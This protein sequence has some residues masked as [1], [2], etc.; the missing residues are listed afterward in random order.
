MHLRPTILNLTLMLPFK[1]GIV[2]AIN[3][4]IVEPVAKTNQ[5]TSGLSY[6]IWFLMTHLF[7][8]LADLHLFLDIICHHPNTHGSKVEVWFAEFV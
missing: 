3:K 2:V 5:P 4:T 1:T 6:M 7:T 8:G